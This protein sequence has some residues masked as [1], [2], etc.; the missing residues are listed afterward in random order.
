LT[1]GQGAVFDW[2]RIEFNFLQRKSLLFKY[3]FYAP[4]VKQFFFLA[5][6]YRRNKK[7]RAIWDGLK[8]FHFYFLSIKK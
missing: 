2:K 6:T 5:D 7:K 4:A 1:S 3:R 8:I